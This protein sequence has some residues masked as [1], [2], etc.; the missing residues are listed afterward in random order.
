MNQTKDPE[1]RRPT[2]A[3]LSILRVLWKRGNSTVREVRD[4]LANKGDQIGYTTV[5]KLLQIMHGKGL[6]ERDASDRAHIFRPT[7]TKNHTQKQFVSDL[8]TRVFDGSPSQL[9]LQALGD[10]ATP[11][12]EELDQI[13]RVIADLEATTEE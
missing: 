12:N 4:V 8:V 3:E 6:V 2:E 13:K 5:L 11:S 9:I 7:K 1:L 10:S